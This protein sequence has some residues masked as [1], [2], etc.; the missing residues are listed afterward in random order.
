MK[1]C[2][3]KHLI[4]N[5]RFVG[6]KPARLEGFSLIKVFVLHAKDVG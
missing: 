2:W 6:S 5:Q 4:V 1:A 3:L